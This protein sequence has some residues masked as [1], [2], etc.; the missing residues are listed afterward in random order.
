MNLKDQFSLLIPTYNRYPYLLRLLKYYES[1]HFPFRIY[2][3]DSSDE[4]MQ[5]DEL[6]KLLAEDSIYYQKYDPGVFLSEKIA[7]GCGYVITPYV[8]LC[9]DDDFLVPT[10]ISECINYLENNPAFSLAHGKFI[11]H[12]INQKKNKFEWEAGYVFDKSLEIE[13]PLDRINHH[14][15]NYCITFYSVHRSDIFKL[16]WEDTGIYTLNFGFS[17]L[18]PSVLSILY[19]KMKILN[20][21][22]SSREENNY[23]WFNA[24]YYKVMYSHENNNLAIFGL[25]KHLQKKIN[26]NHKNANKIARIFIE[27]YANP[28]LIQ[29]H[30]V[31]KT[32]AYKL[33]R[34]IYNFSLLKIFLKPIKE[35]RIRQIIS[36]SLYKIWYILR[37]KDFENERAIIKNIVL[38]TNI[39]IEVLN[40]TRRMYSDFVKRN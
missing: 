40:K 19:G 31:K 17:E 36:R 6:K 2:V 37:L 29:H 9:G 35:I 8:A 14:L 22:Y 18:F 15:L 30:N 24:D 11:F 33:F 27:S 34:T 23:Y 4:E 38:S 3:L 26:L 25:S 10:G 16:I 28:F 7:K 20:V 21:F 1:F 39:D 32:S 5:S 12:R 13:N